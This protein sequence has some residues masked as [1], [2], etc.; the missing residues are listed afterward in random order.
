MKITE[1]KGYALEVPGTKYVWRKGLPGEGETRDVFFLRILTDEG[2]EGYCIWHQHGKILTLI[3]KEVFKSIIGEDPLD[4]EY[5][6]QK[7]WDMD[8]I[9]M[10]PIYAQ[11]CLDVA[12]W[13]LGAKKADMPLYKFIGAVRNKILASEIGKS[14]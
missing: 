11:G 9:K 4:R 1:I 5:I 12:L 2:I 13:D 6:W 8:R 14:L 10:M 7:I 3:A